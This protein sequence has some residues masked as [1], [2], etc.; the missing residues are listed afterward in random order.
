[1]PKA[2][3]LIVDDEPDLREILAAYLRGR[4]YEV[5]VAEEGGV[6]LEFL[7][8]VACDLALI[9]IDMADMNGLTLA[10]A[11]RTHQ[12]R[13]PVSLILMSGL[14]TT[15]RWIQ[16]R[17]IGVERLL[18]KPFSAQQLWHEINEALAAG[19]SKAGGG[20][21]QLPGFSTGI[22]ASQSGKASGA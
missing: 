12:P 22:F 5:F 2:R 4:D 19:P 11:I 10:L 17:A 20:R 21:L 7:R 1:M 3:I 9:D 15:D 14:I 18:A 16:A 13:L 6:A 8:E